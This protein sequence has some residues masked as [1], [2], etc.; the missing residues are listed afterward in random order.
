MDS[1]RR[2]R[3]AVSP[4]P[5]G[6]EGETADECGCSGHPATGRGCERNRPAAASPGDRSGASADAPTGAWRAITIAARRP[7]RPARQGGSRRL[8][9]SVRRPLRGPQG[10]APAS[11]TPAHESWSGFLPV[12]VSRLDKYTDL[13]NYPLTVEGG[14]QIMAGR[15]R[16]AGGL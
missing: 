2:P 5:R 1:Y 4:G 3:G 16:E 9:V 10:H 8:C 7:P 12:P 14:T 6:P 15:D 11:L 13:G